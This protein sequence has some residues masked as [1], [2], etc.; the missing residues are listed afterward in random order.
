MHSRRKPHDQ[1]ARGSVAE[2]RNRAR[3]IV[4]MLHANVFEETRQAAAAPAIEAESAHYSGLVMVVT[5]TM[6]GIVIA[7]PVI[8]RMRQDFYPSAIS[9][10]DAAGRFGLQGHVRYAEAGLQHQPR[11][12]QQRRPIVEI[13]QTYMRRK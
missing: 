10:I 13:V 12:L 7:V 9:G 2:G 11:G 4:R 3:V 1:Q 8:A 5:M 6:T